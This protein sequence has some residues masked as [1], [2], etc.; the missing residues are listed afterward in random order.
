MDGAFEYTA[1]YAV[2]CLFTHDLDLHLIRLTCG[3]AGF[4]QTFCIGGK[5]NIRK[6][7]GIYLFI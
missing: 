1:I 5:P 6:C 7:I 2:N 4:I 3:N